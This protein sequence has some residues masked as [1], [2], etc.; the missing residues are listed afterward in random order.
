MICFKDLPNNLLREYQLRLVKM[1]SFVHEKCEKNCLRYF[2]TWGSCL[3]AVRHNGFIPWDDDLDIAMPRGDYEKLF[4]LYEAE[5]WEDYSLSKPSKGVITGVHIMTINDE[6]TTLILESNKNSKTSHGIK[7]DIC[8]I[9]GCPNNGFRRKMQTF[10]CLIFGLFAA[11]RLPN[12]N[13]ISES[14]KSSKV[15]RAIAWLMLFVFRGK[16][17]REKIWMKAEKRLSKYDYNTSDYIRCLQGK[18]FPKSIFGDPV[19]LMFENQMRPVPQQY[20]LYLK[21]CYGNYMELPPA[22]KRIPQIK[23]ID[24]SLDISYKKRTN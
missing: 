3:G 13:P 10:H 19:F 1:L 8:P 17:I 21:T 23:A 9:D 24:F 5:K 11:Q 2:L 7:I 14:S 12:H 20:D 22:E 18:P 15:M 4:A 16:R 6:N